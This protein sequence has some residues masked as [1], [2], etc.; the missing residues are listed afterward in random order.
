MS[1][2]TSTAFTDGNSK[3]ETFKNRAQLKVSSPPWSQIKALLVG[4]RATLDV[5]YTAKATTYDKDGKGIKTWEVSDV[6]RSVQ[7]LEQEDIDL[8]T[9]VEGNG[10]LNDGDGTIGHGLTMDIA[11]GSSICERTCFACIT[12]LDKKASE[13]EGEGKSSCIDQCLR[14]R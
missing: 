1:E 10:S 13:Q 9:G 3:S 14:R 8:W 2:E 7:V 6:F 12:H 11:K 4:T 5:P